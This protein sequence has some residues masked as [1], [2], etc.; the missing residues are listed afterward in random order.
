[1]A[2]AS[3]AGSKTDRTLSSTSL[4]FSYKGNTHAMLTPLGSYFGHLRSLV[5]HTILMAS[6]HQRAHSRHLRERS[7]LEGCWSHKL[8][9]LWREAESTKVDELTARGYNWGPSPSKPF[10]LE[11]WRAKASYVDH[12]IHL[13][14]NISS[15]SWAPANSIAMDI[16]DRSITGTGS[17]VSWYGQE[18]GRSSAS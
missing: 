4:P 2:E 15:T 13:V 12:L 8:H 9:F 7:A 14:T 3:L 1:M 11:S 16:V 18:L 17:M 10:V 5:L 6:Q